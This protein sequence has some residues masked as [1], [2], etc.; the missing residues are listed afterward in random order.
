MINQPKITGLIITFN[1]EK[2]IVS[3][4]ENLSFVDE[5]IV[6]DSFSIDNTVKLLSQYKNIKIVQNKFENYTSQRNFAI[7]FVQNPWILFLDAD[8]RMPKKLIAEI[9]NEVLKTESS[10]AYF[11]KRKFYFAGKPLNFSGTQNDKNIRLF[12][13]NNAFYDQ[14]KS[15]HE[16]LIFDGKPGILNNKLQHYSVTDY[17]SYYKK[18]IQYGQLKA[19]DLFK[20]GKKYNILVHISK[21][22]FKF[23]KSYIIQLGFLDGTN[24]FKICYLQAVSVFETY[25]YLKKIEKYNE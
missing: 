18:M 15:V 1:E 20:K 19:Q 7:K 4:I 22:L 23:F 14:T 11:F 5:I 6:V 12:K 16:T 21:T 8:E 17:D 2:N 3:L 13:N 25:S 9:Q 24:G 10:D